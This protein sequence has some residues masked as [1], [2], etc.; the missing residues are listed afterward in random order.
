MG[1]PRLKIN[2]LVNHNA[3]LRGDIDRVGD[4]RAE[5]VVDYSLGERHVLSTRVVCHSL[6][7]ALLDHLGDTL[8]LDQL[9]HRGG[10][11]RAVVG[12]SVCHIQGLHDKL[13]HFLVA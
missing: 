6:V 10:S 12:A 5:I 1:V 8:G 4:Q 7:V 11:V 13:E 3:Y 2:L 9:T